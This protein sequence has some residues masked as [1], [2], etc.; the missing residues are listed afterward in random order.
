MHSER[1]KL[2][3]IF[4]LYE[5]N[6]VKETMKRWDLLKADHRSFSRYENIRHSLTFQFQQMYFKNFVG[7]A[8]CSTQGFIFNTWFSVGFENRHLW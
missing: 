3:A 4:G 7:N 8:F 5:C 1:P 6:R 2:Y